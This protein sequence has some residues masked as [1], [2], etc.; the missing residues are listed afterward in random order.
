MKKFSI[1]FVVLMVMSLL[2]VHVPPAAA[3]AAATEAPVVRLLPKR[4]PL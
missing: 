2:S 4:Q 1:M 3:P